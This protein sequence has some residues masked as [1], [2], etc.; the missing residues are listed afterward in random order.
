MSPPG[1]CSCSGTWA[2]TLGGPSVA[3]SRA[4]LQKDAWVW[5]CV[6][7]GESPGALQV[8]ILSFFPGALE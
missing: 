4:R 6:G 2:R 3:G 5:A 7:T 8:L 1:W